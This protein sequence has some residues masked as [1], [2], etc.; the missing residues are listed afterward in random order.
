MQTTFSMLMTQLLE[1]SNMSVAE[2]H[3]EMQQ[4]EINI[5]Y[6]TLAAYKNFTV[7]PTYERALV[8]LNFFNYKMQNDDLIKMLDHSRNE[9]KK[10]RITDKSSIRQGIQLSAKYFSSSLSGLDLDIMI[11]RRINELYDHNG[12][13]SSYVTDLI[14]KDLIESGYLK[15]D[16]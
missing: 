15:E 4:A 6:P 16:E 5:S 1:E 12:N 11:T 7:V 8:I 9:I 13:M 3:R 2:L 14:K 10:M